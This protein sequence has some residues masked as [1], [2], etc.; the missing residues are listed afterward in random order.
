MTF[1]VGTFEDAIERAKKAVA[2]FPQEPRINFPNASDLFSTMTARRW[3]IVRKMAGAGPMSIRELSRRLGRDVKGVHGDVHALLDC[4]VLSRT[5]EGQIVFPFD[6]VHV[7]VM[8][9]AA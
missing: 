1:G 2:G 6:A 3:E 9:E 5:D 8:I 4:G 7:D